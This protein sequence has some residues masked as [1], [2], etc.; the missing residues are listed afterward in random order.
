MRYR[1]N[2]RFR[3][4]SAGSH[5]AGT[6]QP[7]ALE[8]LAPTGY[9]LAQLRSKSWDEFARPDAPV[10]D[11]IITLC[12][13]AAGEQ[14]PYWP[15]HPLAAHWCIDN[16]VAVHGT[17]DQR[18][19]AFHQAFHAIRAHLNI[20]V[21]LPLQMLEKHALHREVMAIGRPAA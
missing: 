6:V 15:G 17:E 14:C 5:P 8:Q 16:P 18:R 1:G 13:A 7:L 11:F 20:F 10:M 12:D 21:S 9:P 4:F 2:S 3:G 19:A